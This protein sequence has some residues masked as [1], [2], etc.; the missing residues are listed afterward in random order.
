MSNRIPADGYHVVKEGEN[1]QSIAF[2][3][4]H[5]ADTVWHH[6][7]NAG[8]KKSRPDPN[9]LA[10]GDRVFIPPLRERTVS[11]ETNQL[12]RFRVKNTPSLLRFRPLVFGKPLA[13]EPYKLAVDDDP[14]IDGVIVDHGT[15]ERFVRPDAREATLTVGSGG[16][17][18]IYRLNLRTLA[19]GSELLG[20]QMRLEQLG[21]YDGPLDGKDSAETR[22]AIAMFQER[23]GIEQT[24]IADQQTKD[25]LL[26]QHGR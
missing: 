1:I 14:P 24:G 19:P 12:H 7:N 16:S 26:Q 9:V 10:V 11:R 25:L 20:V 22:N 17:E 21:H 8:L 3:Y 15:I 2:L 5:F 18:I 4:G 23:Q 6:E 13:N